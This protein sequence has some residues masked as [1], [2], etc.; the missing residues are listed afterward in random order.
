MRN[1]YDLKGKVRAMHMPMSPMHP[2]VKDSY[3]V[4]RAPHMN[5]INYNFYAIRK[6]NSWSSDDFA[7]QREAEKAAL[8][9]LRSLPAKGTK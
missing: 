3:N 5:G 1:N 8:H 4:Y 9:H 6:D 2:T 7:T